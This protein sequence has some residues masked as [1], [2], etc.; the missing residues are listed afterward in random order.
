MKNIVYLLIFIIISFVGCSSTTSPKNNEV[1][2]GKVSIVR[3]D[4]DVYRYLQQPDAVNQSLLKEKYPLLLPAFGRIAMDNSDPETF[5]ASLKDY[6]SHPALMQIYKDALKTFEDVF[7]YEE[8][9][10]NANHLISVNLKGSKLPELAMHI[11]GFR[12]N[13]IILNNLISISTDKYLGD[14]Y[15]AYQ[16]FFKPYERQQMQPQFVVRDYLKAWLMSDI[17]RPETDDN[18]LLSAIVNEGKILY[19][20]STLLPEKEANDII[21]Y[22]LS[23]LNW[24]KQNEKTT[25]QSIV[26]QNYLF[27]TDNMIITRFINDGVNTIIISPESP[28]RLGSW[29]G[30]QIVKQY[31][32]KKDASLQEI[33]DTNAQTILKEAKYNP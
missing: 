31:A 7:V 8:E 30:W 27:S 24:C 19:A 20:L 3:F 15:P 25:W 13:V 18:N 26:K 29:V 21:S 17:I 23:Q 12:E 14:N 28:G 33:I 1:H 5:F 22:T 10:A 16:D 32:K 11:S 2:Q 9:L 4:K 6:F